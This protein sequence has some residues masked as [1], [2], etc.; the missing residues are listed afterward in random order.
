MVSCL[1]IEHDEEQRQRLSTMLDA[2]GMECTSVARPDDGLAVCRSQHP[3]V[4][5]MKASEAKAIRPFLRLAGAK[6]A[7]QRPPVLLFYS[8]TPDMGVIGETIL[9]GAAEFLVLP[10]DRDL[11]SFK[12]KQSGV[13]PAKAA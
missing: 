4:V 1:L 8:N 3:D 6:N 5:M 7:A 2:L 12:L 10:F 9:N 11:L 13:L